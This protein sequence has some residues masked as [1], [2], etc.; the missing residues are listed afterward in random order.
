MSPRH[1]RRRRRRHPV[2][3]G[4]TALGLLLAALASC[5]DD[6]PAAADGPV[7]ADY[8]GMGRWPGPSPTVCI[9]DHTGSV[10]N[11]GAGFPVRQA[12]DEFEDLP[13]TL[14]VETDCRGYGNV[15]DVVTVNDRDSAHSAW[16]R[17]ERDDNGRYT[18]G[19]VELNLAQAFRLDP[20]GWRLVLVH[21]LGH[22][23]GLE[24]TFEGES[25]MHPLTYTDVDGLTDTD[26]DQIRQ[27]YEQEAPAT[28][29]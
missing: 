7:P 22:I 25:V 12:V 3:A 6:A 16:T 21:E 27:L 11:T 14:V 17:T 4:V 2:L 24:H 10:G 26:R 23:A 8:N 5:S 9:E 18:S 29:P 1:A 20:R 13:I 19:R 15:V 28:R